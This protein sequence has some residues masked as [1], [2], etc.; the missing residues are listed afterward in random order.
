VGL[1]L[2]GYSFER[3]VAPWIWAIAGSLCLVGCGLLVTQRR[4]AST[5]DEGDLVDHHQQPPTTPRPE[6]PLRWIL[7]LAKVPLFLSLPILLFAAGL[8][9]GAQPF[10]RAI[11]PW[12]WLIGGAFAAVGAGILLL[13]LILLLDSESESDQS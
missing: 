13:R 2:L 1:H 10:Y 6:K 8:T 9:F 11:S 3:A 5:M 7:S 4:L 12:F